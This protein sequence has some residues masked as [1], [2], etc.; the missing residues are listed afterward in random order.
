MGVCRYVL[1]CWKK[2][3][4]ATELLQRCFIV[5]VAVPTLDARSRVIQPV[6]G[7]AQRIMCRLSNRP[8]NFCVIDRRN[9][10]WPPCFAEAKEPNG[11]RHVLQKKLYIKRK[12]KTRTL[13]KRN[14]FFP[15]LHIHQP[16]ITNQG[17][18]KGS[19]RYSV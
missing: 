8:K 1:A 12:T 19:Q 16:S 4:G 7:S 3:V 13:Q 6:T 11:K 14:T 15:K 9:G 5:H 17:D 18:Q 10:A 2:P